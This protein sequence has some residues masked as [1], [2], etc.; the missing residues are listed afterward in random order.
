M[1]AESQTIR[2]G[3]LL[4]RKK[5]KVSR[6]YMPTLRRER[7]LSPGFLEDG[8]EEEEDTDYYDSRRSAARRRFDEDLEMEAQAEKRII[9]AKKEPK[10]NLREPA[11]S[12]KRKGIESDEESPPRKIP[13][14]HRRMAIVYDSDED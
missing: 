14:A 5:E 13:A 3:V 11:S 6:K 9:N 10:Q 1:K 7:Q 12:H 4:N 2:A 8:P